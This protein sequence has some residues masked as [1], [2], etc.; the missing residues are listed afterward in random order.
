[1]FTQ[2]NSMNYIAIELWERLGINDPSERQIEILESLLSNTI[3]YKTIIIDERLSSKE[4]LCLILAAQGKS[5]KES[6]LLLALSQTQVEFY[7]K[8]IRRK[9]ACSSMAQAVYEGIRYGY[10]REK[11]A[12]ENFST[13]IPIQKKVVG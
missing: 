9:L 10:L 3:I 1:M 8:E 5:S 12:K 2:V 4:S 6:A 7:R 11:T 13:V